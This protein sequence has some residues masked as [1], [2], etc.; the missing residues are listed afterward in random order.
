MLI[1]I[2]LNVILELFEPEMW[3]NYKRWI[4][5]CNILTSDPAVDQGT[6]ASGRKYLDGLNWVQMW[7]PQEAGGCQTI[8]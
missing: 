6:G 2:N 5:K 1:K 4:W 8:I 7:R 3:P